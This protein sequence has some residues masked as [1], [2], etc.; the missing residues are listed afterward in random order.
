VNTEKCK[1]EEIDVWEDNS[2]KNNYEGR[3]Y[4][5]YL[6]E[7]KHSYEDIARLIIDQGW[8]DEIMEH[9]SNPEFV[10]DAKGEL[11]NG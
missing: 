6:I 10:K 5:G 4:F 11:I 3:Q 2:S 8:Q 9:L 1:I 7:E